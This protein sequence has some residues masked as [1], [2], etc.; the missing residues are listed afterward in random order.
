MDNTTST[1]QELYNRTPRRHNDE[2]IKEI[3]N[4]VTEYEDI[5]MSI[6]AINPITKN[7][8]LLFLMWLKR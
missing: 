6:E 5:L 7:N 3:N 4:I 1:L 2:N 8:Y